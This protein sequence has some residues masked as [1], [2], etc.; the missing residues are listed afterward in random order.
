MPDMYPKSLPQFL[1][2]LAEQ[3]QLIRIDAEVSADGEITEIARRVA[4]NQGPAML[5]TKVAGRTFPLLTNLLASEQRVLLALGCDS[6]DELASAFAERLRK[7]AFVPE[8]IVTTAACQQVVQLGRDIQL[9]E[10]SWL[11]SNGTGSPP[12]IA[13]AVVVS[14]DPESQQRSLASYDVTVVERRR[15]ELRYRLRDPIARQIAA[16]AER[17]ERMPVAVTVGGPPM[18]SLL[19]GISEGRDLDSYQVASCLV[20]EPI[21]VAGGRSVPLQVPAE[22]ELI[23]EGFIDA[24]SVSQ[25]SSGG[26]QV[27]EIEVEMVT[28]RAEPVLVATTDDEQSTLLRYISRIE[29]PGLLRRQPAIV[30]LVRPQ[31][32]P[33]QYAFVAIE[34][35][36]EQQSREIAAALWAE[37]SLR[38]V[39]FIMLVD[40]NVDVNDEAQVWRCMAEHA[41]PR[42]DV[43]FPPASVDGERAASVAVD[44]TAK[45]GD[46]Q[47]L[48]T[49]T[50]R[51]QQEADA[52]ELRE[53]VSERWSEYGMK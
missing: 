28:H 16:Y 33:R 47:V 7:E 38:D 11:R 8:K 50:H 29:L 27:A 21:E 34:K 2:R 37:E 30:D 1:E 31:T 49:S 18:L 45:C 25:N 10:F 13:A 15:L 6:L 17:E 19:A 46:S 22:A 12:A 3:D 4:A 48:A 53:L 35:H 39:K 5:L 40:A 20:G 44:A 9:D 14:T 51:R 26:L 23:I 52:R 36:F 42:H 32:G 24:E 41:D 43:I